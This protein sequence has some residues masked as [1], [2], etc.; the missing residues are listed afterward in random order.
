[1]IYYSTLNNL[2]TGLIEQ[3]IFHVKLICRFRNKSNPSKNFVMKK[4]LFVLFIAFITVDVNA[5]LANTKWKGTLNFDN[6]VDAIFSFSNDTLDVLNA[7]DNSS[8]ETMKFTVK[9][10]IISFQKLFGHSECDN[11]TIGNYKFTVSGDD[12]TL[13]LVSDAC[14]DRAQVIGDMKLNKEK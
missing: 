4:I 1:M 10:S 7:M 13:K 5:Q 9:D 14:D 12:M 11:N 8:M 2:D 6:P 3:I